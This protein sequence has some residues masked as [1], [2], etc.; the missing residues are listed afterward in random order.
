MS[1]YLYRL[2]A[3][4]PAMMG[5]GPTPDEHVVLDQHQAYL[6]DLLARDVVL[7][8]GRTETTDYSTFALVLFRADSEGEARRV[9]SDDPAVT[10]RVM[11][12]ELY[13]YRVNLSGDLSHLT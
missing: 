8:A 10:A 2:Q 5:S 3:T 11:R 4:R 6:Q 9:V 13:P 7:L 12:A 1:L